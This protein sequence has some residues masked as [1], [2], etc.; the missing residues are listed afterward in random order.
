MTI[1]AAT[2]SPIPSD[3]LH[4]DSHSRLSPEEIAKA[5]ARHQREHPNQ[6]RT[7]KP[8]KTTPHR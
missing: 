5:L 7:A 8:Q 6:A 4:S 2:N 1:P 3:V